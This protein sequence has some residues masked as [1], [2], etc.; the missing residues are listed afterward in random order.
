MKLF[1]KIETMQM[2]EWIIYHHFSCCYVHIMS[3][4]LYMGIIN[5]ILSVRPA[6]T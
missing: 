6:L 1:Y 4:F 2:N 5:G 3:G